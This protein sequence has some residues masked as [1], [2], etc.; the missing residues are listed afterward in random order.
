MKVAGFAKFAKLKNVIKGTQFSLFLKLNSGLLK[1][2]RLFM[3]TLL[4]LHLVS[5]LFS[6]LPSFEHNPLNGWI[7]RNGLEDAP[8]LRIYLNSFYFCFVSLTTVGYG[9]IQAQTNCRLLSN[10]TRSFSP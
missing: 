8:N 5:C 1:T 7:H 9:D 10:K 3:V 6:A 2:L 4:C